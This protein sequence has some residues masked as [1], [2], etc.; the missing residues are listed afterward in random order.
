M[1]AFSVRVKDE[2]IMIFNYIFQKIKDKNNTG[3]KPIEDQNVI[4]V[5]PT[6]AENE[7]F[8]KGRFL[9]SSDFKTRVFALKDRTAK[10]KRRFLHLWTDL[11]ILTLLT[12][13]L[14]GR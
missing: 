1:Y 5:L 14:Y 11:R 4:N 13:A 9:K 6:V 7:S 10:M 3:G 8:L 12:T 2:D